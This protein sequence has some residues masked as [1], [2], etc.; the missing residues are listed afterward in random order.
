MGGVVRGF[1][2]WWNFIRSM[3]HIGNYYITGSITL[4]PGLQEV[5]IPTEYPNPTSVFISCD[6]PDGAI[7]TCI[8]DLNWV[9]CRVLTQGFVLYA[10]IQ[11][12]TCTVNYYVRYDATHTPDVVVP[13]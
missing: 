2:W 4:G 9:A 3:F 13:S 10:N 6:E 8:G 12:N 11:S 7:T 5:Q 1:D